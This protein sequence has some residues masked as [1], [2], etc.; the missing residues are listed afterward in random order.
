LPGRRAAFDHAAEAAFDEQPALQ[1]TARRF[2]AQLLLDLGEIEVAERRLA[3]V[4]LESASGAPLRH[5]PVSWT[6]P[7]STSAVTESMLTPALV[8]VASPRILEKVIFRGERASE[9]VS[10]ETIRS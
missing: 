9:P 4:R 10:L 3:L 6:V 5:A 2:V 1:R 7:P 8:I